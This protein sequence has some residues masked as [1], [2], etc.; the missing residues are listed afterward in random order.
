MFFLEEFIIK[1]TLEQNLTKKGIVTEWLDKN[2]RVKLTKQG[3]RET[4]KLFLKVIYGENA[5]ELNEGIDRYVKEQRNFIEDFKTLIA[6]MNS[7][8]YTP[9]YIHG[10]CG[11]I[12]KFF[13]RHGLKI[14]DDEW[15]DMNASLL[16]SHVVTTQDEILTKD[17][18]KSVLN[19]LTILHRAIA[20][21]LIS[22]GAR[23]G[24]TLQLRIADLNLDADPPSANIRVEYTKKGIG[25]R[26]MWFS[27]EAKDAIEAWLKIKNSKSKPGGFGRYPNDMVF[28]ISITGFHLIWHNALKKAGLDKQDPITHYYLYHVHT[29][30]KFFS[31][32]MTEAGVPESIIHAWMGHKGYLDSAYKRYTKDKLAQMY[33]QHMDAVTIYEH[34]SVDVKSFLEE[35]EAKTKQIRELQ[36]NESFVYGLLEK[37]NIPNDRPL[38]DRL[39]ELVIKLQIPPQPIPIKSEPVTPIQVMQKPSIS[40]EPKNSDIDIPIKPREILEQPIAKIEL[41]PMTRACPLKGAYVPKRECDQCS[42]TNGFF[43]FSDCYNMQQRFKRGIPTD[44]DK[45][46]FDFA[47]VNGEYQIEK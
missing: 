43:A 9:C 18:F 5:F 30:R 46:L 19:H 38:K 6:Y 44:Q 45:A 12:R 34:S 13:S 39:I 10:T 26:V 35:L 41:P 15:K 23:I 24:E 40:N 8:R 3:Y 11:R 25:G 47:I 42:K 7:K 1:S 21:F 17:Q 36:E 28:G 22:T 29:L 4:L 32:K 14:T 16:P 31:T 33:K 37:Y 20:L 2:F 27:Y